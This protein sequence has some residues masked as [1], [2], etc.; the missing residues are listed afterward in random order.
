MAEEDKF[1]KEIDSLHKDIYN[2]IF[3]CKEQEQMFILEYLKDFSRSKAYK[4]TFPESEE[5]SIKTIYLESHKLYHKLEDGIEKIANIMIRKTAVESLQIITRLKNAATFDMKDVH[6]ADG[7]IKNI[8]DMP[9]SITRLM[10][11]VKVRQDARGKL[12]IDKKG[13]PRFIP[14]ETIEIKFPARMKAED[15]LAKY[16]ELYSD[17]LEIEGFT[18]LVDLVKKKMKADNK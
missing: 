17:K 18:S 5:L 12:E 8:H 7:S 6:N 4:R 9:D 15:M 2:I 10:E 14:T 16:Y 3:E 13:S 11:S 1:K